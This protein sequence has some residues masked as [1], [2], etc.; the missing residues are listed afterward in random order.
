MIDMSRRSQGGICSG[1]ADNV[2]LPTKFKKER[3][4]IL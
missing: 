2:V 3:I 1:A 4:H